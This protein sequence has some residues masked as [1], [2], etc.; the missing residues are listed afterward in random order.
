PTPRECASRAALRPAKKIKNKGGKQITDEA[1]FRQ[2]KG[3]DS[4]KIPL[5]SP[6]FKGGRYGPHVF[7]PFK[8]GGLRGICSRICH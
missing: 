1:L 7:S 2:A 8:K 6:F 3:M 5:E 4:G